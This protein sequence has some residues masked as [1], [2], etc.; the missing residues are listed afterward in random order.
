MLRRQRNF[1]SL[2]IFHLYI[3]AIIFCEY[4]IR[5]KIIKTNG[6]RENSIKIDHFPAC[7]EHLEIQEL[8]WKTTRHYDRV[9]PG[10]SSILGV[11]AQLESLILGAINWLVAFFPALLFS[12]RLQGMFVHAKLRDTNSRYSCPTIRIEDARRCEKDWK[13]I[14]RMNPGN[15]IHSRWLAPT[16]LF[17]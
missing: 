13:K 4:E 2:Q 15:A 16:F 17:T 11:L 6:K 12:S 5:K 7:C 14:R 1:V 10:A 3:F 8:D 9:D